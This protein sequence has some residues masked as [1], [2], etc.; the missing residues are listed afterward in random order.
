MLVLAAFAAIYVIW[1]STYLFIR[2]AIESIPPFT[3]A[4]VRFLLAGG[5]LFLW[6]RMRKVPAPTA[7]QW[8]TSLL[9]GSLLLVAGNGC[10]VWAEKTVP[11]GLVSL[12]ISA[13][14]IWVAIFDW[15]RPGGAPPRLAAV[16][17]LALGLVGLAMLL[18]PEV[19][20]NINLAGCLVAVLG[21]ISWSFGTIYSRSANVPESPF[22]ATATQML[23]A[24]AILL[25]LSIFSGELARLDPSTLSFRSIA[26]LLYLIFFGSIVAFSA[27]VW[28]IRVDNPTRVATYAYVNPVVALLLGWLFAGEHLHVSMLGPAAVIILSVAMVTRFTPKRR[29]TPTVECKPEIPSTSG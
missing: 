6:L 3:M 29:P 12:L 8:R 28:L 18:Q 5:L 17:G 22:M 21:S 24:G 19:S 11:S 20:P 26:A 16:F 2:F 23:S 9:I 7:L 25:L 15:W 13:T 14:P 4:A 1:G 27:F 10:V